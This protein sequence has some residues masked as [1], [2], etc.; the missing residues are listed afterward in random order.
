ML[1]VYWDLLSVQLIVYPIIGGW[2]R[3]GYQE[4]WRLVIVWTILK[5]IQNLKCED[6]SLV[7]NTEDSA[8]KSEELIVEFLTG[9]TD[10]K[11]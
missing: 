10:C 1:D 11:V 7:L 5:D 9:I 8:T 2:W 3:M 4:V 6:K